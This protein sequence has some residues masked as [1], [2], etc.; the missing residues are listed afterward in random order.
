MVDNLNNTTVHVVG[1]TY[2]YTVPVEM[3][4]EDYIYSKFRE[5]NNII[6]RFDHLN[7]D[8]MLEDRELMMLVNHMPEDNLVPDLSLTDEQRKAF[9][10][11]HILDAFNS[12]NATHISME[13]LNAYFSQSQGY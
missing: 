12:I 11:Q 9:H 6:W 13:E 8:E 3:L 10:H 2:K 1:T 4:I 5:I 7:M